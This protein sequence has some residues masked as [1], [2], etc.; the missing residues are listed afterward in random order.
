MIVVKATVN[1]GSYQYDEFHL[2]DSPEE[3]EKVEKAYEQDK[4]SFLY[5]YEFYSYDL[6]ELDLENVQ[7]QEVKEMKLT[8]FVK[9]SAFIAAQQ[10]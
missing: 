4:N 3:V 7:M 8:D 2:L 6:E 9:V 1:R 5:S 10:L